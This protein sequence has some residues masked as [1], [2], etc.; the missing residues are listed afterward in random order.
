MDKKRLMIEA[1]TYGSLIIQGIRMVEDGRRIYK[2]HKPKSLGF[3]PPQRKRWLP[4][5]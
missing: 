2:G 1:L 4:R 3:A 5:R